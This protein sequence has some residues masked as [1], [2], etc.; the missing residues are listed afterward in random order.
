MRPSRLVSPAVARSRARSTTWSASCSGARHCSVTSPGP[1]RVSVY[2]VPSRSTTGSSGSTVGSPT[3]SMRKSPLAVSDCV[4]ASV[5]VQSLVGASHRPSN[6]SAVNAERGQQDRDRAEDHRRLAPAELERVDAVD[7]HRHRDAEA[8]GEAERGQGEAGLGRQHRRVGEEARRD[9]H[10][11]PADQGQ[12]PAARGPRQAI[13]GGDEQRVPPRPRP[14]PTSSSPRW[15]GRCRTGGSGRGRG[16]V[17]T[18]TRSAALSTPVCAYASGH[19][20]SS[21]MPADGRD[22]RDAEAAQRHAAGA[23]DRDREHEASRRRARTGRGR[24]GT[25]PRATPRGPP[26]AGPG[27]CGR[28][29]AS[30]RRTMRSSR[31]G[32]SA[33]STSGPEAALRDRVAGHRVDAV[34]E[35]GG[36]RGPAQVDDAARQ[37]VGAERAERDREHDGEGLREPDRTEEHGAHARR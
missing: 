33:N 28:R 27:P 24:P 2:P 16:R 5:L 29:P 23:R 12:H 17:G 36:E 20:N 26:A 30:P 18:R 21:T 22:H 7:E 25:R 11:R 34:G 4:N 10:H 19:G 6:T 8:E 14:G 31:N 13:A 9:P 15:P 1:L 3:H 35:A 32:S 37:P